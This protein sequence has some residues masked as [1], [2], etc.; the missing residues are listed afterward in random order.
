MDLA[1]PTQRPPKVRSAS[2]VIV[3]TQQFLN[4]KSFLSN[5]IV[6]KLKQWK[7]QP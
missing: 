7:I 5:K 2:D 3:A 6:A 4:V 1:L